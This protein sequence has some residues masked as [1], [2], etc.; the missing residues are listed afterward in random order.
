MW[1]CSRQSKQTNWG[2]N[3][4]DSKR[5]VLWVFFFLPEWDFGWQQTMRLSDTLSIN[6]VMWHAISF[7]L[8]ERQDKET[9]K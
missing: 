3:G 6:D 1:N 4:E 5:P 8:K 2:Y 9:E 7:L